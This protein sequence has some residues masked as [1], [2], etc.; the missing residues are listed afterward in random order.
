MSTWFVVVARVLQTDPILNSALTNARCEFEE[1]D[2]GQ[3]IG[4]GMIRHVNISFYGDIIHS[5]SSYV[6]FGAIRLL[7]NDD[8][9]GDPMA[10][11]IIHPEISF[12]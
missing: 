10:S 4:T 6:I 2:L 5:G 7:A 9:S 8:Y 11:P 3:R 12:H 1:G